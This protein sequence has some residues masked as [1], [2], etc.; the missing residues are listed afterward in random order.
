MRGLVETSEQAGQTAGMVRI[1]HIR[2]LIAALGL[3]AMTTASAQEGPRKSASGVGPNAMVFASGRITVPQMVRAGIGIDILGIIVI[4]AVFWM[5][6]L[7]VFGIA[8]EGA[9]SW[10]H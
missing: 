3:A 5:I 7:P 10:V 4:T 9:P 6:G 2:V 1:I 8:T